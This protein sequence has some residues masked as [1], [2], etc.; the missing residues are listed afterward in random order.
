MH[1][2]WLWEMHFTLWHRAQLDLCTCIH[3]YTQNLNRSFTDQFP[4]LLPEIGSDIFCPIPSYPITS[5]PI[6]SHPIHPIYP[7]P[8]HPSYPMSSCSS[9]PIPSYPILF[10]PVPSDPILSY[11]IHV[12]YVSHDSLNW[13]LDALTSG[14]NTGPTP[15]NKINGGT[16]SWTMAMKAALLDWTIWG[17]PAQLSSSPRRKG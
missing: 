17:L 5:Y 10:Y 15:K 7:I 6:P 8:S 1:R 16:A 2:L 12:Q 3:T 14:E 9:H 13:S 11:L 4:T